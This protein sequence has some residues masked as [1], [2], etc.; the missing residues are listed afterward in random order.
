[1]KNHWK[2]AWFSDSPVVFFSAITGG[3]EEYTK[4]LKK[5][6]N[7][8]DEAPPHGG[9]SI[10]VWGAINNTGRSQLVRVQGNMTA[11]RYV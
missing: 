5:Q 8:V 3:G 9:G 11:Q 2:H 1:M 6:Q 4:G 10:M 7:C